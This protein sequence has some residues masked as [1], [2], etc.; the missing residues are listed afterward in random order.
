[1]NDF[2]ES[3]MAPDDIESLTKHCYISGGLV[4]QSIHLTTLLLE[5]VNYSTFTHQRCSAADHS[6]G[7]DERSRQQCQPLASRPQIPGETGRRLARSPKGR[8]FS[9]AIIEHK[10]GELQP[11]FNVLFESRALFPHRT[12]IRG[13]LV[14]LALPIG[15]T[16]L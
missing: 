14:A 8:R 2:S 15:G 4:Q 11:G 5:I 13:M 1:M 16:K 3:G 7:H 12:C 10:L 6:V 9:W